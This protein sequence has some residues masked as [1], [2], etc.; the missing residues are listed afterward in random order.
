MISISISTANSTII[1]SMRGCACIHYGEVVGEAIAISEVVFSGHTYYRAIPI[2]IA[3][4]S[5]TATLSITARSSSI[6]LH[7]HSRLIVI[8]VHPSNAKVATTVEYSGLIAAIAVG[9]GQ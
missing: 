6:L 5:T 7:R 2:P 3:T 1:H 9:L 8:A 4:A